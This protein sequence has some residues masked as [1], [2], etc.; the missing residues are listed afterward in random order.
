MIYQIHN[1]MDDKYFPKDESSNTLYGNG[2]DFFVWNVFSVIL[3]LMVQQ[4]KERNR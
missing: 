3:V 2:F 1:G 4:R